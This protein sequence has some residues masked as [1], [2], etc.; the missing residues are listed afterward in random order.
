[1]G[2]NSGDNVQQDIIRNASM[3]SLICDVA[4][5]SI[6]NI[7]LARVTIDWLRCVCDDVCANNRMV[8]KSIG[9]TP[10]LII[11]SLW[12]VGQNPSHFGA[13][14][15]SGRGS[16]KIG[17]K[18]SG[19][20][21]WDKIRDS[22]EN[23]KDTDREGEKGNIEGRGEGQREGEG[24]VKGKYKESP[25]KSSPAFS[26]SQY[27]GNRLQQSCSRFLKQLLT[28][29]SGDQSAPPGSET[30]G[31]PGH[32][33]D[34]PGYPVNKSG[35]GIFNSNVPASGVG[36]KGKGDTSRSSIAVSTV[37]VTATST[38]FTVSSMVLLLGFIRTMH[39]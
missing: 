21:A 6:Q 39:Q 2:S 35:S 25:D 15:G 18:I 14:R 29:T 23:R 31:I 33:L 4:T 20:P 16:E 9:I 7:Q 27:D 34:G 32:I 3:L 24:E 11:L 19:H 12:T 30:S 38:G 22:D 28:G 36:K 13:E 26:I 10:V 17:R 37:V 8:L 5:S 1:M